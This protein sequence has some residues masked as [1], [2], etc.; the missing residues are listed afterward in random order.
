MTTWRH[1]LFK[2]IVAD[3]GCPVSQLY[4]VVV[5]NDSEYLPAGRV[6]KSKPWYL[7]CTYRWW[8]SDPEQHKDGVDASPLLVTFAGRD[9]GDGNSDSVKL[10][11]SGELDNWTWQLGQWEKESGGG[12]GG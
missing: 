1:H 5:D 2:I 12:E 4:P 8:L 10:L 6:A 11:N 9:V 3:F 7:C